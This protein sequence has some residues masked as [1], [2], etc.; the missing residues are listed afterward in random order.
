M[1]K[2]E[3]AI[4]YFE[5]HLV[6]LE[7]HCKHGGD[8]ALEA[9]DHTR[10]AIEALKKQVPRA[11]GCYPVPAFGYCPVCGN[12]VEYGNDY[13]SHCGQATSKQLA[14]CVSSQCFE[15]S[16]HAIGGKVCEQ[17]ADKVDEIRRIHEEE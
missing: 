15:C 14:I 11:A 1:N 3:K 8:F 13:C 17:Y 9:R 7:N 2:F 4:R 12:E 10:T 6:V 16:K 5:E